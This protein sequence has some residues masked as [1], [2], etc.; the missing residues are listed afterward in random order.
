MQ[1]DTNKDIDIYNLYY[2]HSY[3]VDTNALSVW[4]NGVKQYDY[5]EDNPNIINLEDG[6]IDGVGTYVIE[7]PEGTEKQ[8]CMRIKLD[9]RNR[10]PGADNMFISPISLSSG[11]I[12]LFVSGIRQ[13]RE[14]F[15]LVDSYTIQIFGNIIGGSSDF[16]LDE[17]N[18]YKKPEL[19]NIN[20]TPNIKYYDVKNYDEILIELRSD[21]NLREITVP[22]RVQGQN[23]FSLAE[24]NLPEDLFYT[25][26][27]ITIYV[28][29]V[30][31]DCRELKKNEIEDRKIYLIDRSFGIGNYYIKP[32]KDFITFEWR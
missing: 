12:R 31:F 2:K 17:N 32:D 29:G 8:S 1:F 14:S 30:L 5:I 28:D 9:Y 20:N 6:S 4:L 19:V 22:V 27:L 10:V 13:P 18:I 24:D 26:D 3:P 16:N 21:F 7:R 25:A 11:N 23:L 15:L